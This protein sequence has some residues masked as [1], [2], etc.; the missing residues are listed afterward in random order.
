MPH[1]ILE[2][3][4]NLQES[5][6]RLQH[7]LSSCQNILVQG[8]STQLNSCKSRLIMCE[9]FIVGDGEANKAFLHLTVKALKKPERTPELLKS[10]SEK[11]QQEIINNCARSMSQQNVSVSVEMVELHNSYTQ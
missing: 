2:A 4:A 11:L 9:V 6:E 10:I 5:N 7:V 1:L 8:L 3:S